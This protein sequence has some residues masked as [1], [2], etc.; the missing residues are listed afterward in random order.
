MWIHVSVDLHM[1]L[2]IFCVCKAEKLCV[3][4]FSVWMVILSSA[5]V[6]RH[7]RDKNKD[8]KDRNTDELK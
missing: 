6:G 7:T 2:R 5:S 4:M 8:K 3:V 1:Q